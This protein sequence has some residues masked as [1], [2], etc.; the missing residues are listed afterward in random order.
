LSMGAVFG[1]LAGINHFG[2]RMSGV[3]SWHALGVLTHFWALFLGVNLTFWPMH[4]TGLS[5]MPRRIPDYPDA[6][7]EANMLSSFGSIIVRF[8]LHSLPVRP[9]MRMSPHRLVLISGQSPDRSR[10]R[11]FQDGDNSTWVKS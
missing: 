6:W 10:I 7:I 11:W 2:S 9:E 1:M 4:W 8:A 3:K 5:G